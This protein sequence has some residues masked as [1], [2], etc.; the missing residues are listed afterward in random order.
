MRIRNSFGTNFINEGKKLFLDENEPYI[1]DRTRQFY[2]FDIVPISAPRMTQSDK[3]RLNPEHP[4]INKRQRIVVT[5]YFAYKNDLLTQAKKMN[6]EIKSVL[7]VLFIIPMP[8]SWS[9]KEKKK[10]NGLPC[11]VKPDT[12][13]LVKAIKDTFC[14]N[15]SHIWKEISEKRWG[16]RGSVIIFD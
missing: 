6:Y 14:K 2:L 5:K 12:D 1:L 10:M 16:F 8:N 3:W 11:K 4:D 13:N 7:D 9:E 15:D